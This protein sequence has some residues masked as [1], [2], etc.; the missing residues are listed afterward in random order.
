MGYASLTPE[1]R[2]KKHMTQSRSKKGG[3]KISSKREKT[4]DIYGNKKKEKKTNN[5]FGW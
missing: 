1:E 2:Y 5:Y 3:Y 4:A